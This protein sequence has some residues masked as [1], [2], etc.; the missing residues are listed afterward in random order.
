MNTRTNQST[1]KNANPRSIQAARSRFTN[2]P[3]TKLRH[4]DTSDM[5]TARIKLSQF[6]H[7]FASA[8]SSGKDRPKR[9]T[10]ARRR[11]ADERHLAPALFV[12]LVS[13][14]F[15]LCG[16]V[17]QAEETVPEITVDSFSATSARASID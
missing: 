8:T 11:V 7:R 6:F 9:K 2:K 12:P 1:A 10:P 5:K 17:A 13:G 3:T 15:L 16:T 14:L 4:G